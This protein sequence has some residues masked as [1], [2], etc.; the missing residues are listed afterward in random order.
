VNDGTYDITI[1]DQDG[2][3]TV[4]A[5]KEGKTVAENLPFSQIKSLPEDV[6]AKVEEISRGIRVGAEGAS[7]DE[8]GTEGKPVPATPVQGSKELRA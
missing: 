4:D 1:R 6:R 7:G 3:R 8:E 2:V 5:E